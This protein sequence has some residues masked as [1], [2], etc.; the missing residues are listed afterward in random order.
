MCLSFSSNLRL[1]PPWVNKLFLAAILC[2]AICITAIVH[3]YK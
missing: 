3:V 1:F 2:V